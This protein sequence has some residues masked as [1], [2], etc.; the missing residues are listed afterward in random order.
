MFGLILDILGY[1]LIA[2]IITL[3]V[4]S[5]KMIILNGKIKKMKKSGD[6]AQYLLVA[7]HYKKEGQIKKAMEWYE[8]AA[9]GGFPEASYEL[10]TYY[11]MPNTGY[12]N[13]EKAFQYCLEAAKGGVEQAQ[14]KIGCYFENGIG[15]EK[16]TT[17]ALYWFEQ[18]VKNGNKLAASKVSRLKG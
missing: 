6:P 10:S 5:I 9:Q 12:Q 17:Q 14:Y 4:V 16:D 1:V 7:Q 11:D 2:L 8:K 13:Q 15:T 3:I 18:A